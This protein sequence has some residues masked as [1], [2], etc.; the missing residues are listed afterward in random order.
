MSGG[1]SRDEMTTVY[2]QVDVGFE[3]SL[4]SDKPRGFI[5][6]AWSGS[7][8]EP[9]YSSRTRLFGSTEMHISHF[10]RND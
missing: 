4:H 9:E 2:E 8:S 7:E 1:V 6:S 3:T 5:V 10:N